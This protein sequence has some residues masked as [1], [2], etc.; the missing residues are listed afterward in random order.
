MN[1]ERCPNIRGKQLGGESFD[2]CELTERPS[3]RIKPCLL[4][5]GE[6]CE[7]WEEIKREWNE[8]SK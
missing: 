4:E 8:E 7:E 5:S 6:K 2:Y 1:L 3:G